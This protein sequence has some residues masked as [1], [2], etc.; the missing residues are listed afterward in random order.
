[1][2]QKQKVQESDTTTDAIKNPARTQTKNKCQP[3][4]KCQSQKISQ[5]Y[6]AMNNI[7]TLS[8]PFPGFFL[9]KKAITFE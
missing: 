4:R 5:L 1:M 8:I 3:G 6:K 2:P 9:L 7:L